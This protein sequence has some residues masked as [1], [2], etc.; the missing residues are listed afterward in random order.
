[1]PIKLG[2]LGAADIAFRK[3]LP[4]LNKSEDIIFYGIAS[5]DQSKANHF[6]NIFGGRV[7]ESYENLLKDKMIDAIY[8]PLPP[9]L[10]FEWAKMALQYGKHI[11]MEKPFCTN[12]SQTIELLN[13]AKKKKKVLHENYMFIFHKQLEVIK[14]ILLEHKLGEIRLV[15]ISFGFPKRAETDF[16]YNKELGGGALLDCGGYTLKLASELM[17]D[18][19]IVKHKKLEKETY[20]VDLY[21]A[22]TLENRFGEIIQIAFGMDNSYRCELEIWGSNGYLKAPRIFT[23]PADFS[24]NLKIEINNKKFIVNVGKDDQFF[25]SI[26]YFIQLVND[27]DLQQENYKNILKQAILLDRMED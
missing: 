12:L 23:A 5:R 25:K 1:M 2:V 26:Q 27:P 17:G 16:R 7:Y 15:R 11:Y 21:G 6:T 22:A 9:A 10:H 8:I 14:N 20:D 18:D 3:F 19:L 24:V 4:A 13:L